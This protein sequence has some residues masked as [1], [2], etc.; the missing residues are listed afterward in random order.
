LTK[1][2]FTSFISSS[3]LSFSELDDVAEAEDLAIAFLTLATT[4]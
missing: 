1:T 2:F 3:D 4:S